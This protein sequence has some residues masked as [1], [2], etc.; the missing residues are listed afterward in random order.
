MSVARAILPAVGFTRLSQVASLLF[1]E[2]GS[3]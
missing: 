3:E 2:I 1:I